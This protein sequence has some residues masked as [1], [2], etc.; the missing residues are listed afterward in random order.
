MRKD[1]E[2]MA[3]SAATGAVR[4][5]FEYEGDQIRLISQQ[6]VDLFSPASDPKSAAVHESGFW[7]ELRD[8]NLRVLHRQVTHDPIITHPEVFSDQ[9]GKSIVRSPTPIRKG[10]FTVLIPRIAASDHLALIRMD[11]KA[12]SQARAALPAVGPVGE[13]ARFTLKKPASNDSQGDKK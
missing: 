9:P 1:D 5:I 3:Q 12:R 6:D 2:R 11:T 10:A 13:I 8:A 7:L 4:L